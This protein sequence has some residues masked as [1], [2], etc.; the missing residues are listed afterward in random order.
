MKSEIVIVGNR[1]LLRTAEHPDGK[2]LRVLPEGSS[3]EEIMEAL[4]SAA[5]PTG[6]DDG[7]FTGRK[8]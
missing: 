8:D 2:V 4:L 6:I 5:V 7:P 3:E 1:I